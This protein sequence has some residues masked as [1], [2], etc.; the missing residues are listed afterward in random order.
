MARGAAPVLIYLGAGVS[1]AWFKIRGTKHGAGQKVP[2]G[3]IWEIDL[4]KMGAEDDSRAAYP[5][6]M[7]GAKLGGKGRATIKT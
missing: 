7:G 5:W 6:L 3:N 4:E 1:R 2:N